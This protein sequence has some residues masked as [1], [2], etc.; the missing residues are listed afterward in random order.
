MHMPA[1]ALMGGVTSLFAAF[2]TLVLDQPPV[3]ASLVIAAP[4]SHNVPL[5]PKADL[6][7]K[8]AM[9]EDVMR[10]F[11]RDVMAASALNK[12]SGPS[13]TQLAGLHFA[14]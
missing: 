13:G 1:M 3:L 9:D 14:F 6:L 8:V 12:V 2:G 4:L 10:A 5:E 11:S 7:A